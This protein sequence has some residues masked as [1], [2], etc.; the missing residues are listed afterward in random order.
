MIIS[1]AGKR[2]GVLSKSRGGAH[3]VKIDQ[4]M[5]DKVVEI[6]EAN[7]AVTIKRMNE[8]LKDSLPDKPS[9]SD[10]RLGRICDGMFYSL[11]K[12]S[13]QPQ[14]RNSDSCLLYTSPSPR[15]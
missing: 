10:N 2:D 6:I 9:I 4:E 14:N 7:P 13:I 3:N 5:K 12:L 15:D 8:I 11:K 1:R